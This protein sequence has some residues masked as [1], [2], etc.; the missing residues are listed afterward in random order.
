MSNF[1]TSEERNADTNY[2]VG[3]YVYGKYQDD[4]MDVLFSL[5]MMLQRPPNYIGDKK[6][7]QNHSKIKL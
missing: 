2:V 7:K 5:N 6:L 3:L 1:Q 4:Q